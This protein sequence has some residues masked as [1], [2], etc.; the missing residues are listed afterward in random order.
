MFLINIII[1]H[2]FT[3]YNKNFKLPAGMTI[4]NFSTDMTI[5]N[6]SADMTVLIYLWMI[7][8]D[9]GFLSTQ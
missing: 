7:K 2:Y 9:A 6:L 3:L 1:L 4:F 8:I 5:F